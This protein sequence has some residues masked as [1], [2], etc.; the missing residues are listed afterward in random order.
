MAV[1]KQMNNLVYDWPIM[2]HQ[3]RYSAIMPPSRIS[4]TN[5]TSSTAR[6]NT[7]VEP[8]VSLTLIS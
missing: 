2:H 7:E 3:Q 8:G 1:S 4:R 6:V 5:K